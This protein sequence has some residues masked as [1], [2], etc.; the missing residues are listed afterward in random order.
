MMQYLQTYT[1]VRKR[2]EPLEEVDEQLPKSSKTGRCPTDALHSCFKN[3]DVNS[4]N[5]IQP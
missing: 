3:A 2:S 1:C 4:Y 5:E